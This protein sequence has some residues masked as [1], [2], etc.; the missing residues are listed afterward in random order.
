MPGFVTHYLFG[1]QTCRQLSDRS[2]RQ[3]ILLNH[4]AFSL[5]L[6]G[7][8]VF[9][10]YLPSDR[11][12][13]ENPGNLAHDRRTGAFFANLLQAR[14]RYQSDP[15]RL[16]IADAYLMGF[17]GHYTLDTHAHPFVYA[18]TDYDPQNPPEA[19]PYFALHGGLE[20]D[21]DIVLLRARKDIPSSRFPMNHT[22]ALRPLQRQ[23]IAELL[24]HAYR[25]TYGDLEG[26]SFQ[27]KQMAAATRWMYTLSGF[28]RDRFGL[29]KRLM[30][31]AEKKL[32]GYEKYT[33]MMPADD[34]PI[35]KDPLNLQKKAW[36]HPWTGQSSDQS[37]DEIMADAGIHYAGRLTAY[38]RMR[39]LP[40]DSRERAEFL[41]EY[42]NLH[43]SSGLDCGSK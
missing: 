16:A 35:N 2:L 15:P 29:K 26:F 5:G 23:V 41:Q 22:I 12:Y 36:V 31:L 33:C 39:V 8:D 13:P 34:R 30:S 40:A 3:E 38:Q 27:V 6:Q 14:D 9:F 42:G 1:A 37:F 25:E 10:Y 21:L 32:L 20:T 7:P 4:A 18:F 28:L 43:F 17:I 24:C 19:G 11:L